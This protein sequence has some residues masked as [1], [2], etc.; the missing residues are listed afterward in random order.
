[1]VRIA[2][3][4]VIHA[5]LRW[6][7]TSEKILWSMDMAHDVNLNNYTSHI[8]SVMY[9]E[10][11]WKTPKYSHRELQ[12]DHPWGLPAY[13]TEPRLQD[14][15]KLPT[16]MPRSRRDQYLGSSPLHASTMVLIRNLITV[17][18]RPQF[19]LMFYEYLKT[20]HAGE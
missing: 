17:N 1:M 4:M 19:H 2:R 14:S 5:A 16:W 18:I 10:G 15:K 11:F 3:T 20:V 12:N 9:P 8:S 7:D 6:P 13:V